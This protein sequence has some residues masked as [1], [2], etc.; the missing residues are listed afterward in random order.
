MAY[1]PDLSEKMPE[2]Q[3]SRKYFWTILFSVAL[4][5]ARAAIDEAS[6]KRDDLQRKRGRPPIDDLIDGDWLDLLEKHPFQSGK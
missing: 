2:K 4:K 6:H 3:V 1:Y 5:F